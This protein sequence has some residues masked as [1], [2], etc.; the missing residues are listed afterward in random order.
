[1]HVAAVV[2]KLLLL[3]C[4]VVVLQVAEFLRSNATQLD[5]M[6]L[7]ELFGHHSDF[8]IATMHAW[9]DMERYAGMPID[10]AL[11]RLLEQFRL[12]GEAQKIDRIME[13]FAEVRGIGGL[14]G[15]LA[16]WR[17]VIG[18]AQRCGRDAH[19]PLSQQCMYNSMAAAG[20]RGW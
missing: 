1:M 20:K 12:P 19:P 18:G 9:V 15:G 6:Q 16:A 7:G 14:P 17:A 4:V 3:T 13:K 10:T 11:R 5:K 8:S 2:F